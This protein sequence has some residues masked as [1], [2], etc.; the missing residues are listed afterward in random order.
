MLFGGPVL[1]IA[2][3]LVQIESCDTMMILSML[4]TSAPLA[5]VPSSRSL[6][7]SGDLM[8]DHSGFRFSVATCHSWISGPP[9]RLHIVRLVPFRFSLFGFFLVHLDSTAMEPS[10]LTDL[11]NYSGEILLVCHYY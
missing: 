2:L 10:I 8:Y 5:R 6:I 4:A 1:L 11:C 7:R 3:V 9:G